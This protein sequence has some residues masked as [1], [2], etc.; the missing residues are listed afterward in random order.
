MPGVSA[1]TAKKGKMSKMAAIRVKA[2]KAIVEVALHDELEEGSYEFGR[3][4]K[5]LG[6]GQI[7]LVCQDKMEYRGVIRGLLRKRGVTPI[8]IDDVVILGKREWESRA[9]G[10][11]ACYDVMG[12]LERKDAERLCTRGAIPDWM[13]SH[14]SVKISDHDDKGFEFEDITS[15]ND[16]VDV[17]A[18]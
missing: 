2:N 6:N 10:G 7:K 1:H 12:V 4:T 13:V 3:V 8:G 18:I 17:D 9:T 11:S 15:D 5:H 14:G 16:D